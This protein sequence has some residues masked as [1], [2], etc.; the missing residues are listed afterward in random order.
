MTLFH[1]LII[2]LAV[3]GVA[4]AA[5]S[6]KLSRDEA[7]WTKWMDKEIREMLRREARRGIGLDAVENAD[8]FT[9]TYYWFK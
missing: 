4:N 9:N 7:E 2:V 1:I 5:I 3:I 6:I 8:S